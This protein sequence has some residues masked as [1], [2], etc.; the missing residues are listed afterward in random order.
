MLL[1]SHG[2]NCEA[3]ESALVLQARI[4]VRTSRNMPYHWESREN[5]K[6]GIR[7]S[8]L[9]GH[10]LWFLGVIF[11]ILGVI[12]DAT[13]TNLGLEP[14][15]WL[16]LAAVVLLLGVCLFIGLAISWYLAEKK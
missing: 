10:I 1:T 9:L 6:A 13:N 7:T 5:M 16:V 12:G 2:S 14:L 8:G 15:S 4:S 3:A 11:A